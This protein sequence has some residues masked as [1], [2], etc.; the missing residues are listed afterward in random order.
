MNKE[1]KYVIVDEEEYELIPAQEEYEISDEESAELHELFRT[2]DSE[3]TE[4]ELDE[5]MDEL[6][7][8]D[9]NDLT[10]RAIERAEAGEDGPY[11]FETVE[12]PVKITLHM[13]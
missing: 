11:I 12:G 1:K 8:Y 4:G 13:K 10:S 9:L 2:M 5:I 6:S 3:G 7:K